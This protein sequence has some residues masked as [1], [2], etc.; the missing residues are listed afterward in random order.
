MKLKRICLSL[1]EIQLLFIFALF[2]SFHI[3]CAVVLMY[4]ASD[5]VSLLFLEIIMLNEEN[6][7]RYVNIYSTQ[8][9][10]IAC[11]SSHI[12][13]F[14]LAVLSCGTYEVWDVV[15]LT[16]LVPLL[17]CN[18]IPNWIHQINQIWWWEILAGWHSN[19]NVCCKCKPIFGFLAEFRMAA[20]YR[21]KCVYSML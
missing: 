4:F 3:M 15:I 8:M 9:W 13:K 5:T 21:P 16:L 10:R 14:I 19:L 2:I 18:Q 17:Q 1:N 20:Y 6:V 7:I 11:L 12:I